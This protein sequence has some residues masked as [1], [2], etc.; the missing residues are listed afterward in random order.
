MAEPRLDF[1]SS[2]FLGF[3][4][5]SVTL[6]R[7]TTGR[8]AALGAS[9]LVRAAERALASLTEFPRVWLSPSTLHLLMDLLLNCKQRSLGLVLERD[10]YPL[11][12]EPARALA[13]SLGL[14]WFERGSSASLTRVL[15]ALPRGRAVVLAETLKTEAPYLAPLAD[16]AQSCQEHGALL[17]L[18]DSQGSGL[19]GKPCSTSMFGC[20]GQGALA[21]FAFPKYRVVL[22]ASLAKS[23]G[24]PAAFAAGTEQLIESFFSSGLMALHASPASEHDAVLVIGTLRANARHGDLRR[25]RLAERIRTLRALCHERGLPLIRSPLPLQRLSSQPAAC[26][27]RTWRGLRR[28]GIHSLLLRGTD[29]QRLAVAFV[30]RADHRIHELHRLAQ[31]LTRT[32]VPSAVP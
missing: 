11:L 23:F 1:T 14:R 6:E 18:D 7:V 20:G 19:L 24:V 22:L 8:P 5:R 27:Q 4:P 15:R 25:A 17:V 31:A 9:A 10:A 29:P 26:A 2:A 13:G 3:Q 16:Y 12:R 30:L 28:L 32:W 21:R